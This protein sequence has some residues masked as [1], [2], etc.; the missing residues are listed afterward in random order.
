MLADFPLRCWCLPC[1]DFPPSFNAHS[2]VPTSNTTFATALVMYLG[3]FRC[4]TEI[5]MNGAFPLRY[6]RF[7]CVDYTAVQKASQVVPTTK[8]HLSHGFRDRLAAS[9][10]LQLKS[11][12]NGALDKWKRWTISDELSEGCGSRDAEWEYDM[13]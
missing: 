1:V 9:F 10:A 13:L 7:P 12:F 6:S 3:R 4:E 11:E 5:G 8:Y 2:V